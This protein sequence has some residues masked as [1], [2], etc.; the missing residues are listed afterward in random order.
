MTDLV[1]I[2][3]DVCGMCVCVCGMWDVCGM[4]VCVGYM[5]V[6]DMCVCVCGAGRCTFQGAGFVLHVQ[7]YAGKGVKSF[8]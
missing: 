2:D 7:G 3:V 5:C 4:C 6:W 1:T 8:R